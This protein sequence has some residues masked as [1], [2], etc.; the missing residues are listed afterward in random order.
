MK[1]KKDVIL[2]VVTVILVIVLIVGFIYDRN[3]ALL[4]RTN[5]YDFAV[6]D[7]IEVVKMNKVG[8]L[9][10]RAA[11]EAKLKIKDGDAEGY[12]ITLATVYGGKGQM[13]D[14]EQYKQYESEVLTNVSLKPNP[15]QDSFV[16]ALG[17][18]LK[19][20]STEN[21]VYIISLESES[22]A[23]IYLYYSRK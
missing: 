8:F 15:M 13:F 6:D 4:E 16:W 19:A 18:P 10:A 5:L 12:I 9:F 7:N 1:G 23:Y 11:Y 22:D 3:S 21:I 17:S 14:Y 20:D 2:V